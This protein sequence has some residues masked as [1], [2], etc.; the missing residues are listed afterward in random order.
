MPSPSNPHRSPLSGA[1]LN[2][3]L[4]SAVCIGLIALYH[5]FFR[6]SPEQIA[7]QTAARVAERIER[8]RLQKQNAAVAEAI[9]RSRL[10]DAIAASAALR[11]A[12]T[13]YFMAQGQMPSSMLE[14]GL[15]G[16]PPSP[17]IT[18]VRLL[19]N[20][21]LQLQLNLR[22]ETPSH[23]LLIPQLYNNGAIHWRCES[24][25]IAD[26]ESLGADCRYTGA[27]APGR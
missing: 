10:S 19:Q 18:Q 26:I 23:V 27:H 4:C 13:E 9:F 7:E 24:P 3:T 22:P 16:T 20:G 15:D 6:R 11:L 1:L 25:D 14:T 2:I 8:E 17:W 12:V 21:E 5:H